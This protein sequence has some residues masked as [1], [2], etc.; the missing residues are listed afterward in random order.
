MPKV[1]DALRKISPPF[2]V[3]KFRLR[4][5]PYHLDTWLS[6][7]SR[8]AKRVGNDSASLVAD[9][10]TYTTKGSTQG[11]LTVDRLPESFATGGLVL[12]GG[13]TPYVLE[14]VYTDTL[15]DVDEPT[16][17]LTL[18]G[19]ESDTVLEGTLVQSIGYPI[20]PDTE[21][22][23]DSTTI[24]V[25]SDVPIYYGDVILVGWRELIVTESVSTS[26]NV[27]DLT[28]SD[29]LSFEGV[30][31]TQPIWL[32][33]LPAYSHQVVVPAEGDTS[34]TGSPVPTI[35]PWIMEIGQGGWGA[36]IDPDV[37][38]RAELLDATFTQRGDAITGWHDGYGVSNTI[39]G[40][41]LTLM[42][43]WE[44][45]W[46]RPLRP[47]K[48]LVQTAENGRFWLHS[49]MYPGFNLDVSSQI[50]IKSTNPGTLIIAGINGVD[51]S[52]VVLSHAGGDIIMNIP[53]PAASVV[54]ESLDF[55]W[56]GDSGQD[57]VEIG[58][59]I[60][61]ENPIRWI[62]YSIV[63]HA[64]IPYDW[65][66][67]GIHIKPLILSIDLIAAIYDGTKR[68]DSSLLLGE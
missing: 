1:F 6:G 33:T 65:S 47:G 16:H 3:P 38:S 13:K 37:Y 20:T 60:P 15:S 46:I 36:D 54:V 12:L 21:Y 61:A 42:E 25:N 45:D 2:R 50:R 59:W 48:A 18:E 43:L 67:V 56:V 40:Y 10:Q 44:G 58:S 62:N 64:S 14:S 27:Y 41:D 57:Q 22:A 39:R 17:L 32:K 5:I 11:L 49:N 9:T 8:F 53:A 55:G 52:D 7:A 28:L 4:G 19:A 66:M 29:T 23:S 68:L 26:D 24:T 63:S 51:G 31:D 30:G 35:G 34:S